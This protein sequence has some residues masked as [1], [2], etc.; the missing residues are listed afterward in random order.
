MSREIAF[1]EEV[2]TFSSMPGIFVGREQIHP[3]ALADPKYHVFY[4]KQVR[5]IAYAV[6]IQL[7]FLLLADQ[8]WIWNIAYTQAPDTHGNVWVPS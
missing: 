2:R 1:E 4:M 8:P 6:A 7:C 3:S 5:P